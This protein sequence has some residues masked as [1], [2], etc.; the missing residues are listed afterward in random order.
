MFQNAQTFHERLDTVD[1][2]ETPTAP[3]PQYAAFPFG[4]IPP[5]ECPAGR[6]TAATCTGTAR[7][8]DRDSRSP[9]C[10]AR[11]RGAVEEES[12]IQSSVLAR[13]WRFGHPRSVRDYLWLVSR[14]DG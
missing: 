1:F 8:K 9:V 12:V 11:P 6:K 4:I 14:G 3:G 10:L 7:C 5:L 2:F 13:L